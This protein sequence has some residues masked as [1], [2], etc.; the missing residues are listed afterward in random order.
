MIGTSWVRVSYADLE[1]YFLS[2]GGSTLYEV[3]TVCICICENVQLENG[4]KS[5]N[6][7][8]KNP[9]TCAC[10]SVDMR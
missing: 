8:D 6:S 5:V 2:H 3:H 1:K 7:T 10:A 4:S 9:Q